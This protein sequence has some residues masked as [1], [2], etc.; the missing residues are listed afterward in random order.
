MVQV[1]Q[2]HL[3]IQFQFLMPQE[4]E[5]C[6]E[7]DNQFFDLRQ[8]RFEDVLEQL[9]CFLSD[10]TILICLGENIFSLCPYY[11]WRIIWV[12]VVVSNHINHLSIILHLHKFIYL[13]SG[14][15]S[16]TIVLPVLSLP[17]KKPLIKNALLAVLNGISQ[18]L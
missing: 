12:C 15:N 4:M 7:S 10:L 14:K 8:K 3:S 2:F 9:K 11:G 13:L 6:I 16:V 1:R 17:L 5:F 18:R